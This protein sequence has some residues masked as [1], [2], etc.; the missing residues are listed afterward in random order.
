M[1]TA[2][3]LGFAGSVPAVFF[4]NCPGMGNALGIWYNS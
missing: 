2:K 4:Q 3:S 1:K